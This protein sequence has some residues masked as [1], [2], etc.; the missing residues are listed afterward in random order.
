MIK[1]FINKISV[2]TIGYK[3][4]VYD[5]R[6]WV[7]K[8]ARLI[9][10][11]ILRFN[12]C[13]KGKGADEG[14]RVTVAVAVASGCYHARIAVRVCKL[15]G[16]LSLRKLGQTINWSWPLA[17]FC[18]Y[19]NLFPHARVYVTVGKL[20][21]HWLNSI[22]YFQQQSLTFLLS[23]L[24]ILYIY[25]VNQSEVMQLKFFICFHPL[26]FFFSHFFKYTEY[27]SSN[28]MEMNEKMSKVKSLYIHIIEGKNIYVYMG[29][30]QK[31]Q[32]LSV[33]QMLFNEAHTKP[34]FLFIMG[35]FYILEETTKPYAQD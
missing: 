1:I 11:D 8:S 2:T 28:I 25:S 20:S 12:S 17:T 24:K 13:I 34:H 18:G 26:R 31:Y 27:I 7:C 33:V 35:L 15:K 5:N 14:E 29:H 16:K 19:I 9:R 30:L 21:S 22:Y 23:W 32:E 3:K 6:V 4:R 10:V